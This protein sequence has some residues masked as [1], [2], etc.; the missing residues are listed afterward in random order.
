MPSG[1]HILGQTPV[2]TFMAG[3]EPAFLLEAGDEVVFQ[4][5]DAGRWDAL[6]AAAAAGDP[7]AELVSP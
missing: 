1:W 4:P 3:R 7:V 2:R 6:D 5:V